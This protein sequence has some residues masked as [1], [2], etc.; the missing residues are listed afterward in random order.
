MNRIFTMFAL[1][2]VLPTFALAHD[3]TVRVGWIGP[4]TG[5]G[6]VLGVDAL[7][8]ARQGFE[9]AQQAIGY[10]GPAIELVVED[11]QMNTAKTVTAY[12][13]LVAGQGIKVIM[14]YC[15]G[16]LFAVADRAEKD[17]VL[18]LDPLDCDEDIAKLPSNTLCVAKKTEDFGK[19]VAQAVSER[20]EL[21]TGVLYFENDPF[22]LKAANS[23][24]DEL[25]QRGESVEFFHGYQAG[26]SDFRTLLLQA[27]GRGLKSLLALG[28]DETGSLLVQ[29]KSLGVPAQLYT[30]ATVESPAILAIAGDAADGVRYPEWRASRSPAFEKFM[31]GF[32]TRNGRPPLIEVSTVP[33][34]DVATIVA[35]ALKDKKTLDVDAVKQKFYGLKNYPGASGVITMD[36]DGIVRSFTV[37]MAQRR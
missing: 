7:A 27:K 23:F 28:Y 37:T 32:Q 14:I 4:L 29:A 5:G 2:V 12:N 35:E 36:P 8:A 16:G 17:G 3:P 11:D 6:A 1:I 18:L 24:R 10:S 31:Q 26:Q 19:H 13:K 22:P 9:L 15:Y 20:G 34:F 21:P 30:L 25:R 33:S